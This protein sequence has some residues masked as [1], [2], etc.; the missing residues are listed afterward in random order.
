MKT[1]LFIFSK[2]I[3]CIF[4]FSINRGI[5][6]QEGVF[7]QTLQRVLPAIVKVVA[8]TNLDVVDQMMGEVVVDNTNKLFS[9]GTGFFISEDGLVMTAN[10]V[11]SV[12]TGPITIL[13]LENNQINQ[14]AATIAFSDSL[15]DIAV[16][17]VQRANCPHLQ[18]LDPINLPVG[19]DLAFVGFPLDYYFPVVSK[20]ILSAK[21]DLPLKK[22]YPN[23]HQL[24][25]NQFV[26]H[27]NSGGPLFL[28]ST[29]QVIGVI[30]WR[31]SPDYKNRLILLPK[32]Y[33]PV[34][35]VGGIDP[36]RLSAETYNENLKY[37][38]ELSQFGIGFVPSVEYA[39]QFIK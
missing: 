9:T 36:I 18:L 10:H 22:G 17:K 20:T 13:F 1:R 33:T 21:V 38:G 3:C 5:A 28:S 4:L 12:A 16:L 23:R 7:P 19:T 32:D 37:I 24:V 27:G 39:K 6:Q 29:G 8:E 25:I 15:A 11:I 35:K 34:I 2:V 26:N 31:P 14:I 30:S